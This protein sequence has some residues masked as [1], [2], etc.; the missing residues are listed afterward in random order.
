M[1]MQTLL[2]KYLE[3]WKPLHSHKYCAVPLLWETHGWVGGTQWDSGTLFLVD[4]SKPNHCALGVDCWLCCIA[5]LEKFGLAVRPLGPIT[6]TWGGRSRWQR[7]V[8]ELGLLPMS[9]SNPGCRKI[10]ETSAQ[11]R[12]L[13]TRRK[14]WN[15][16]TRIEVHRISAEECDASFLQ[17]KVPLLF[18]SSP[19][20]WRR[21]DM[22]P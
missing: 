13:C 7:Q 10:S 5:A 4:T 18:F 9:H 2:D 22:A 20:L 11:H 12:N 21:T 6:V 19:G 16:D 3:K 1:N 8:G 17:L 14:P 15:T